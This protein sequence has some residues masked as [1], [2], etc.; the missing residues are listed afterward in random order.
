MAQVKQ[1]RL[2]S[3]FSRIE[4]KG[5]KPTNKRGPRPKY[6]QVSQIVLPKWRAVHFFQD[7]L[8]QGLGELRPIP[9]KQQRYDG[10][11]DNVPYAGEESPVSA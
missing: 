11:V 10:T 4:Y 8:L 2:Y 6:R 1:P 3:L 7:A 5:N 9:V